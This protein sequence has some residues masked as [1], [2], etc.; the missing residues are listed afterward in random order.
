MRFL[1]QF[2]DKTT[3]DKFRAAGSDDPHEFSAA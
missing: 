3:A 2:F 1:Q